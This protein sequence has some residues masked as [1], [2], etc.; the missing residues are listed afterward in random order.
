MTGAQSAD[1]LWCV[2]DVCGALCGRQEGS[3]EVEVAGELYS[4]Q[5]DSTLLVPTGALFTSTRSEGGVTIS[6]TMDPLTKDRAFRHP[7]Q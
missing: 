6:I 5:T 7:S 1:G 4:L 2:S 3:C